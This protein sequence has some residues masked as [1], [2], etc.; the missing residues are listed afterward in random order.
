MT[1]VDP[2]SGVLDQVLLPA[3]SARR[4]GVSVSGLQFFEYIWLLH[5]VRIKSGARLVRLF[6]EEEVEQ[7][8]VARAAK[9]ARQS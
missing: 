8:A 9:K 3:E 2:R 1:T 5:P 6:L 7:L 4:L